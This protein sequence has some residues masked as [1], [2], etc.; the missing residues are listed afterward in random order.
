MA[1]FADF[2]FPGETLS[3]DDS[4]KCAFG[5]YRSRE[6]EMVSSICGMK[7]RERGGGGSDEMSIAHWKSADLIRVSAFMP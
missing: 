7:R 5:V 2:V 4:C 6:K 3:A 1:S